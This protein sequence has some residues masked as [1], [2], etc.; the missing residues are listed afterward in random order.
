MAAL[1]S[2]VR[3]ALRGWRRAPVFTLIAIGSMALGIGA[4]TAIF[5]L[6]DQVLLRTLPIQRPQELVQLIPRGAGYGNNW[7]DGS[8]LSHPMLKDIRDHNQVFSGIFGRFTYDFHTGYAGRTERVAGELVSGSYFQTLGV[9][10]AVGRVFTPDDDRVP[11]GHPVAVL[12]HAYWSSRFAADPSV[13]GKTLVINAHP[14]TII[15][16]AR[17]GFEGVELGLH[18]QVYVPMMMKAQA[19]PGWDALDDPRYRWIR[20]FA[21]LKPGVTPEQA[22]GAL[23]PLYTARLEQEVK[24]QAFANAPQSLRDRF[25]KGELRIEPSARGRSGLRRALTRPLWVL[26][27]IAAGVLLIACANVANLLLARGAGRQREMAVR[28][29]LGASRGRLV[30]QLLAESVLLASA[31][32]LLGLAVAWMGATML[33]GFFGDPESPQPVSAAPDPADSRIHVRGLDAHRHPVRSRAGAA[34]D[35]SERGADAEGSGGERVGR[36]SGAAAQGAGGV[37]GGGLA[38]AV[39]RRRAV[40]PHASQSDGG[41]PRVEDREPDHVRGRSDVE[42]LR[43]GAVAAALEGSARAAARAAGRDGRGRRDDPHSRRQPVD[44]GDDDRGLHAESR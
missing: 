22:R 21:R 1:L 14:Y 39:D 28:L 16:V 17:E 18:T 3:L 5:T 30:R 12:S 26:M 42:R 37:A 15:G 9:P 13:V 19:T 23:Q 6:V 31:G 36:R 43:T 38:D 24:E 7:G 11:N 35:A 41:R 29:A 4:N 20:V 8:E 34:V 25:V 32:G 33:L 27:A 44:H 40:H 10:A 2:D